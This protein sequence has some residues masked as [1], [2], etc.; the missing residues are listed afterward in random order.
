MA[1]DS[2]GTARVD[3]VIDLAQY[4]LAIKRAKNAATGFGADAEAAFDGQSA[5]A[6]RAA[7]SL[8]DFAGNM[9]KSREEVKLLKAAGMGVDPAIIKAA[10]DEINAY[11]QG[12]AAT[13]AEQQKLNALHSEALTWDTER[14]RQQGGGVDFEE[15]QRAAQAATRRAEATEALTLALYRQDAAE[16]ALRNAD[17]VA[18]EERMAQVAWRRAEATDA[19]SIA[20]MRE[21]A[22]EQAVR[23]AADQDR[24]VAAA[25]AAWRR[26]DAVDVLTAELERQEAAERKLAA[27]NNF[28][29]DLQRQEQQIGKTRV[30][31]LEMRAAEMGLT[32]QAAPLIASMKQKEAELGK[33]NHQLDQ[34]KRKINEYGLSQKQMEFA[35]RGVPAQ[36]TDIMVS[37]QGGQAPLTVLLQQGGQ[38]KD[39][40]GGI[41]PAAAALSSQLLKLITPLS[42]GAV[43]IGAIAIAAYKGANELNELNR[44]AI[45]TGE[46]MGATGERLGGMAAQLAEATGSLR[47]A[48][49]AAVNAAAS[50]GKFTADQLAIV[51]GAALALKRDV[52]TALEDTVAQFEKLRKDPVAAIVELNEKQHFLTAAVYDQVRALAEQGK[53]QEAATLAMREYAKVVE[54]R[55]GQARDSVG[56]L[57]K[58]WRNLGAGAKWAWDQMMDIGRTDTLTENI[59][60]QGTK[61]AD[62][63]EQIKQASSSTTLSDTNRTDALRNLRAR[64]VQE[65]A[66]LSKLNR[67]AAE[68]NR[69]DAKKEATQTANET[70]T[71]TQQLID[72]QQSKAQ[73]RT[74]E[75]AKVDAEVDKGVAAARLAGDVALAEKIEAQRA[76]ALKAIDQKYKDPKT[77]SA[78]GNNDAQ[79]AALQAFKDQADITNAAIQGNAR[80]TQAA[81]QANS[82]SAEEY[83]SKMRQNIA[84]ELASNEKALQGQIDYLRSAKDSINN[85][86]QIGELEADLAKTRAKSATELAVLNEQEAA[87]SKKRKQE[88]EDFTNALRSSEQAQQRNYAA[89]AAAIGQGA[90]EAQRVAA[91]TQLYTEQADKLFQL[92]VLKERDKPN[93]AKYAEEEAILRASTERQ[94]QIV[95]DG[96]DNMAQARGS[97][98]N[99]YQR[100]FQNY[101]DD[102]MNI[103]GQAETYFNDT[104]QG[105]EGMLTDLAINGKATV[106]DLTNTIIKQLIR[107]GTQKMI[108]WLMSQFGGG[109]VGPVQ[110][111][112]IPLTMN[113]KGNTYSSA[114]LSAYSGQVY[115]TPQ[116]FAFAKGAGIFAEA[117]PEAIMPLSRTSDGKLGVQSMGAGGGG[118]EVNIIG[119]PA[120]TTVEERQN[121]NGGMSIDV[122]LGQIESKMAGNVANGTGPL[123]TAIRNRYK[124]RESA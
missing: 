114:S 112:S 4:E 62:T 61:I 118:I 74:R 43:A 82:I 75:R 60:Q 77:G 59:Q 113:A 22:A 76:A 92:A 53:Q 117:G 15:Q 25:Q 115:N 94:V 99:G 70:Y 104:T 1:G 67:Q 84:E 11:R 107:L 90:I 3:I 2:I 30:E 44:T 34:S 37:L 41:R 57:E 123:N 54:E 7:R 105:I 73:Q 38:L 108:V 9:G 89:Q 106:T 93:A 50:T 45:M 97:W 98:L 12:V 83:Y 27:G 68:A 10:T 71:T 21:D 88:L 87:A 79:R 46:N 122:L 8:L 26:A 64:L 29:A 5:A 111:E 49:T 35:M 81:F 91:V 96:F 24:D 121:E 109:A 120:G 110:R 32:Q 52:G 39:M 102:M 55:T 116:P 63:I 78:K 19:L 85:R 36:I 124:L 103:A 51:S 72:S 14:T 65:R 16:E 28:L 18:E 95:E 58:A 100:A 42:V 17:R 56:L 86:R 33:Y 20:L 48:T 31:L 101:Q 47:S 119:A 40:F 66:E 80:T 13:A 6:K 23:N 69:A